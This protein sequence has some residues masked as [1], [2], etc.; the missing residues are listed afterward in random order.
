M[1]PPSMRIMA[2]PGVYIPENTQ[3]MSILA[4]IEL[5]APATIAKIICPQVLLICLA[6]KKPAAISS[7]KQT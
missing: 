7:K 2:S 4:T 6:I 1:K 5:A 3:Y